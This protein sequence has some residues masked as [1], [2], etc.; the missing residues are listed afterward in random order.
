MLLSAYIHMYICFCIYICQHISVGIT[1]YFLFSSIYILVLTAF[2]LK[3]A[4]ILSV[5]IIRK[6][7]GCDWRGKK[8]SGHFGLS[9]H[10]SRQGHE[11]SSNTSYSGQ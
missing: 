11:D 7:K 5:I 8:M 10:S 1:E 4:H 3:C 2:F 6:E 9:G